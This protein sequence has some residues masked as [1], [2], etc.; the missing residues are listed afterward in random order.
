MTFWL[1]LDGEGVGRNPHRYIMMGYSD[2][3]GKHSDVVENTQGLRTR[4]CL[5]FLLSVPTDSRVCGYY[6]GYDWTKILQ[7]MPDASIYR[8][9]RPELRA[10]P[11]DEGG[12]FSYVWW[13]DYGLHYL[14][15]MMRIKYGKRSV[16]VWDLGKFF[17]CPFVK[18]LD[19]WKIT[20]KASIDAM[21]VMK[22]RRAEFQ[23]SDRVAI[24]DYMLS[25]CQAL[26]RLGEELHNA[27]TEAGLNLRSWHGPG[28]TASAL[29]RGLNIADKRGEPPPEVQSAADYAFFGGRFEQS[30]IGD[31]SNVYGYDI[32]SAYPWQAYNLPCLEHGKWKRVSHEKDLRT[33]THAVV[34]YRIDDIGPTESWGP[35]PCRLSNGS[36]VFPRAGSSGWIWLGEYLLARANWRGVG[37]DGQAWALYTD[38][39]CQPFAE[40]LDLFRERV[41]IGKS[42]KG[43]VIKLALNSVYGKLAQTI[44]FPK[45]AS[46]IWAGMITSGTRAQLLQLLASHTERSSVLALAT[47]GLFSTQK[48][49]LPA[50]PI[51][52]DTLG[53]WEQSD[54]S[55]MTFVRPGIY[56]SN[57]GTVKTRGISKRQFE[58]QRDAVREA[59][60]CEDERAAIGESTLFGGAR[61]CVYRLPDGEFRRSRYYG[62]WHNIPAYVSLSPA[63]KRRPDWGLH[64]LPGVSSQ[65]YTRTPK[66][67]DAKV[68]AKLAEIFW[69]NQ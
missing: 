10:C 17:Q 68:L 64:I 62:E 25:E 51:A 59:I 61:A 58:E 29:L 13:R 40:L 36:I 35:L 54:A 1:G 38:C 20:D 6:L 16:T 22:Y 56:W 14:A 48:L 57:T 60:D 19:S 46:R 18:A 24:R 26:A 2:G 34:R 3:Y 28:S 66:S 12:G 42:G 15:G 65:P 30:M 11:S 49:S 39:D 63:P 43:I 45:F 67:D 55:D 7:D 27:H 52:P 53:A 33:V 23:Q 69:G 8:L 31:Q 41:R 47:D 5:D 9:L 37:F 44:G 50:A 21:T 4:E 32:V